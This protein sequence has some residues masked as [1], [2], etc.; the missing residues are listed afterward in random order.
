MMNEPLRPCSY[1]D[2]FAGT[3]YCIDYRNYRKVCSKQT[4]G[5]CFME[6]QKSKELRKDE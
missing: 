5:K 6:T 4:T 2:I 1:C 3:I